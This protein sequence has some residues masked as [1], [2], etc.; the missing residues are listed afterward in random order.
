VIVSPL[1]FRNILMPILEYS[2]KSC[3]HQRCCTASPKA[4]RTPPSHTSG[5]WQA[6]MWML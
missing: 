5:F 2:C 1:P 6:R 3:G 4:R